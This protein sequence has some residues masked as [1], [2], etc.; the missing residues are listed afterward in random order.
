MNKVIINALC[1]TD[2]RVPNIKNKNEKNYF[3]TYLKNAFVSLKTARLTN[4]DVDIVLIINFELSD[5]WIKRFKINN[6]IVEKIEFKNY[7]VKNADK[8]SGAYFKLEALEYIV[9]K[10]IYSKILLVD[11][12]TIFVKNINDIWNECDKYLLLYNP[13]YNYSEVD[14]IISRKIYNII[15][16]AESNY[17]HYGGEFVC[18]T[19][20]NIK[21]FL[22][23]CRTVVNHMNLIE[24]NI[25]DL[26]DEQI[27]SIAADMGE[28]DIK[29]SNAYISRIW[30]TIRVREVPGNYRK[31]YI[32]H[33]PSEKEL[34]MIKLYNLLI[35]NKEVKLKKI[36][37]ILNMKSSIIYIII[38]KINRTLNNYVEVLKWKK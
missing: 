19:N 31:L 25:E 17:I 22:K 28:I 15:N 7:L 1:K 35:K 38:K 29:E 16:K 20:D 21:K 2:K 27:I 9:S 6:I 37:R 13:H 11:T 24:K 4:P 26:G 30:N 8:W 36:Y 23:R 10:N 33:V 5:T 14:M 3:E 32:L 18:G 12:D 34:G